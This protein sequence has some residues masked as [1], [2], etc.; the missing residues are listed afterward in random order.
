MLLLQILSE[1][2]HKSG[3]KTFLTNYQKKLVELKPFYHIMLYVTIRDFGH[4]MYLTLKMEC[5]T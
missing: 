3:T 5:G 4:R 2:P 1:I